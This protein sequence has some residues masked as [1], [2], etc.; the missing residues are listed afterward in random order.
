MGTKRSYSNGATARV[1]AERFMREVCRDAARQPTS[2]RLEQWASMLLGAFWER[3]ELAEGCRG[4]DP[5]AVVGEPF[6]KAIARVGTRDAKVALLALARLD[7]G[8]LGPTARELADGLG[9]W[10]SPRVSAVGTARLV[11]ALVASSPGDGE[12]ILFRSD[13]TG[14][15]G[16]M[17]AVYI[18]E[19]LGRIAKHVALLR[20]DAL[21][22][23]T[24]DGPKLHRADLAT[25]CRNVAQAI[26]RT[27]AAANPPVN[28]SFSRYRAIALAR[29]T[30]LA[31]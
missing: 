29:F 2:L 1:G 28:K 30:P 24:E 27:D 10:V 14:S 26:K 18:D 3:R 4:A 11:E 7:R 23:M 16:H 5:V 20:P 8:A 25:T 9:W 22:Q 15:R 19:R 12:A 21:D 31:H 13:G 6:L 17:L